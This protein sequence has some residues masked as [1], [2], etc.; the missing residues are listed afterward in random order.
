MLL[1]DF[2]N[3]VREIRTSQFLSQEDLAHKSGLHRNHI[4]MIERGERNPSLLTIYK[5]TKA[6]NITLKDMMRT[7]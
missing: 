1:K 7:L 3:R 6:L 4:G 2:G 5:I